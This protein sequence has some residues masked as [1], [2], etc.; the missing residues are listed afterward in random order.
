MA[1][2]LRL[3]GLAVLVLVGLYV[4]LEVVAILFGIAWWLLNTLVTLAIVAAV[5]YLLYLFVR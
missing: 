1:D 2:L 3:V 4:A 5:V